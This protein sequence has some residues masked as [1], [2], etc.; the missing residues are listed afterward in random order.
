MPTI[1]RYVLRSTLL[2]LVLFSFNSCKKGNPIL[3][4]L[5][6]EIQLGQQV[7]DEVLSNPQEYGEVL[8]RSQ[9]PQ[10]YAYLDNL[11][12]SILASPD[13][14]YKDEFAW[15]VRI[16]HK[17]GVLNAFAT[18][19]GYIFVYV[20]LIKYLDSADQ[21]AGVLGHEI[22]H[23]DRRHSA[24]N[25]ERVYGVAILLDIVLGSG[26]SQLTQITK[27]LALGLAG[28]SFSRNMEREADEYSVIYL[29]STSYQCDGAA[30]F[31]EKLQAEG[32]CG[33]LTW[34]STHP[35]PCERVQNIND[36]AAALSCDNRPATISSY[37]DFKNSLP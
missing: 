30:G 3:F 11:V 12:N 22:A 20:D 13:V 16:I 24:R 17:P 36:K 32:K 23:S 8:D 19:G 7:R 33:G 34:T 2:L 25:L 37:Q 9:Y 10:A 15:E 4:S 35:D 27:Q 6:D 26:G 1:R 18:P 14:R 21:L 31:F 29:N 5:Q 28:L